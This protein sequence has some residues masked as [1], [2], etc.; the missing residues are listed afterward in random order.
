MRMTGLTPRW[1]H[2]SL[3]LLHQP[4]VA[5]EVFSLKPGV[6]VAD[7]AVG[8]EAARVKALPV[9]NLLIDGLAHELVHWPVNRLVSLGAVPD[10]LADGALLVRGRGAAGVSADRLTGVQS[11]ILEDPTDAEVAEVR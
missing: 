3:E 5:H 4:R 1:R 2:A 11:Q 8:P 9:V 7:V 6:F 10:A